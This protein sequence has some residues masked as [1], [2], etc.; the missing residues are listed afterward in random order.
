MIARWFVPLSVGLI[1]VLLLGIF[2]L[3]DEAAT[4]REAV[5]KLEQAVAAERDA[6]AILRAETQYLARPGR[7]DAPQPE[8]PP[9]EPAP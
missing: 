8:P 7:T 6:Q 5:H 9:P 2:R 3:K 4:T 1:I